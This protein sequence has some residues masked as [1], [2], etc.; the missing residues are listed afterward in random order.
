MGLLD[1]LKAPELDHPR[2][3]RMKYKSGYWT[4][5]VDILGARD[6]ALRLGGT[7]NAI[8]PV[9]EEHWGEMER[10]Y[11]ELADEIADVLYNESYTP[12]REAVDAGE[13][14]GDPA[15]IPML[16]AAEEVWD[17]ATL[18]GVEVDGNLVELSY[19]SEWEVEHRLGVYLRDCQLD[20]FNGS[21]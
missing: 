10:R 7:R 9:A 16:A 13:Y 20:G 12:I 1:F 6:V 17:Y 3:G 18:V 11:T 15:E 2:F 19:V 21:V 5:E 14:P 4:A 8:D